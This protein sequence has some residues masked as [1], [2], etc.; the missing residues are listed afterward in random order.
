MTVAHAIQL[1]ELL[2]IMLIVFGFALRS[3]VRDVT[4]LFRN[5]SLLLRSLLAMNVLLP[6]FAASMGAVLALRPAI[7]IALR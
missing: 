6:L 3:S 4:S 1:T 2:S 7:V 5:P